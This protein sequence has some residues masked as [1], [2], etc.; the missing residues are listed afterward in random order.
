MNETK[1]YQVI[2]SSIA[3]CSKFHKG[4]YFHLKDLITTNICL[5]GNATGGHVFVKMSWEPLIV[6]A[7][8]SGHFFRIWSEV[9]KILREDKVPHPLFPEYFK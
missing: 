3:S 8:L 7:T 9:E 4:D 5:N 1:T 6:I 2:R